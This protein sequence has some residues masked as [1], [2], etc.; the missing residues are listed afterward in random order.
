MALFSK[1]S[2]SKFNISKSEFTHKGSLYEVKMP[3]CGIKCIDFTTE[4]IK[5]LGEHFFKNNKLQIQKHSQKLSLI[6]KL[7]EDKKYYTRGENNNLENISVIQICI[8]NINQ[9]F[10]AKL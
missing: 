1:F 9:N 8:S 10:L 6:W 7:I 2:D 3:F 5:M 4:T